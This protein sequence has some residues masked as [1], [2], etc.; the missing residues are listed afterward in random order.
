VAAPISLKQK[1]GVWFGYAASYA[2]N[3]P[4][5]SH[6]PAFKVSGASVRVTKHFRP[7]DHSFGV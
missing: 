2:G 6:G 7:R 5:T 3:V 4:L 1:V